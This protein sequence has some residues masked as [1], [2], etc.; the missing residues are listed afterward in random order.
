MLSRADKKVG[1]TVPYCTC[2]PTIET[3]GTQDPLNKL[4]SCCEITLSLEYVGEIDLCSQTS[5]EMAR[6]LRAQESCL[7]CGK[8]S[9]HV[10]HHHPA[11]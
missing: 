10:T 11:N 8:C 1:P 6:F 3:D 2:N 4:P 7:S 9:L 5:M